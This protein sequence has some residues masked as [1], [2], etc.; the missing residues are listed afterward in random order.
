MD[1]TRGLDSQGNSDRLWQRHR[2]GE[3]CGRE[4][5]PSNTS[6]AGNPARLVKEGIFWSGQC[7]HRWTDKETQEYQ[8]METDKYNFEGHAEASN[9]FD[10]FDKE[11]SA[12]KSADEKMAYLFEDLS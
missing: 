1:R 7:V 9:H 2:C 10:L 5:I 4:K 12:C 11:L 8:T 3:C 6:W